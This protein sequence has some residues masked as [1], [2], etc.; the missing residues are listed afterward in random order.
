M[1]PRRK[2]TTAGAMRE[3]LNVIARYDA[4]KDRVVVFVI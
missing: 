1:A 4:H 3:K 2:A